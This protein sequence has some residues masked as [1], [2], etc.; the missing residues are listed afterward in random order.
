MV[1][2]EEEEEEEVIARIRRVEESRSI[3]RRKRNRIK[4]ARNQKMKG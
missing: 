3:W 4:S 1:G 2:E